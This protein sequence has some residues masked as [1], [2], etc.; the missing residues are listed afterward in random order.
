FIAHLRQQGE[1]SAD[2]TEARLRLTEAQRRDIELRTRQREGLV[3]ERDAVASAF[4]GVMVVLGAELD[5]LAGRMCSELASL[6]EP[7]A[8]R[9]RLF[10]ECRRIRNHAADAIEAF[11][12]TGS[13]GTPSTEPGA[14]E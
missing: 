3:L 4:D 9:A 2:L 14:A 5:G 12:E 10:D 7:A 11:A 13:T 6:N 8:V 1:T